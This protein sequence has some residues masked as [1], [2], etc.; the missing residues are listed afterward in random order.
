[1]LVFV[2]FLLLLAEVLHGLA[3]FQVIDLC[4]QAR[5]HSTN[6]VMK[7]NQILVVEFLVVILQSI[8]VDSLLLE[9]V[10]QSILTNHITTSLM[11]RGKGIHLLVEV[12][13]LQVVR[14]SGRSSMVGK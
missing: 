10:H 12:D 7:I 4:I 1:M 9:L 5:D 6:I 2:A 11:R 3:Q 13:R 14:C 8:A